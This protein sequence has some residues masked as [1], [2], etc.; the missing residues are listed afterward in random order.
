[1]MLLPAHGPW[2]GTALLCETSPFLVPPRS[3][4]CVVLRCPDL[5]RRVQALPTAWQGC[6]V[7]LYICLSVSV[8]P[9]ELWGISLYFSIASS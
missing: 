7:L 2:K 3:I 5:P 9:M 1:M 4:Q 6:Y 8:K